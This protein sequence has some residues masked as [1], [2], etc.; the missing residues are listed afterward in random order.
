MRIAL[1]ATS[2]VG[3][4][5]GLILLNET[6]LSELGLLGGAEPKTKDPRIRPAESPDGYDV[7]VTDAADPATTVEAALAAQA[8]CVTWTSDAQEQGEA[9]AEHV[10]TLLVGCSL[11]EGITPTLAS[12]EVARTSHVLEEVLA[13]TVPGRPL[14]RGEA[15][16]FP[17]PVGA[18]W[19]REVASDATDRVPTRRLVAPVEGDWAAASARVTGILEDGVVSRVVGVSDLAAHLEAIA[20]AAGAATVSLGHCPSGTALP[21]DCAEPYLGKALEMGLAVATYAV[22]EPQ[23]RRSR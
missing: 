21:T 1:H 12:H 20:L 3:R 17:N 7:V 22:K 6:G 9:F 13:W 15:I 4:R 10:T 23:R 2:E 18:L 5:A 19:G 14:R 8:S 16:P 11:A